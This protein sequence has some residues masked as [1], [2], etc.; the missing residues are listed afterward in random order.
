M[1]SIWAT[2][3]EKTIQYIYFRTIQNFDFYLFYVPIKNAHHIEKDRTLGVPTPYK[4]VW[5]MRISWYFFCVSNFTYRN[6]TPKQK[7]PNLIY[8][9]MTNKNPTFN[10]HHTC[11]VVFTLNFFFCSHVLK[12]QMTNETKWNTSQNWSFKFWICPWTQP[13]KNDM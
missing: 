1:Q 13:H 6:K 2:Q 9:G 12:T 7:K 10:M 3:N 11:W 4:H 8:H 5:H